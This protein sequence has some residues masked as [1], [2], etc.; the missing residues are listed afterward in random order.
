MNEQ[1]DEGGVNPGEWPPQNSG[2]WPKEDR[3]PPELWRAYQGCVWGVG[4]GLKSALPSELPVWERIRAWGS[5]GPS[6]L[7]SNFNCNLTLL[8]TY[9]TKF[10]C[11]Q[12]Y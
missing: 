8:K 2:S 6:F 9:K 4:E 3:C 1:N 7:C 10:E 12:R 11:I 5:L